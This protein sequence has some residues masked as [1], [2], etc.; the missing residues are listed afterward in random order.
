VQGDWPGAAKYW[1]RSTAIIERRADL[2]S[3]RFQDGSSKAEQAS[4]LA[5][6]FSGLVKTTYRLEA[7][8]DAARDR[9]AREMFRKA[10]WVQSSK[11]AASLALMA[12]RSAKGSPNLAILVRE[13][14]DL[15]AEWQAKDK[16]LIEWESE[17]P[18]QRN[19]VANDALL[20]RLRAIDARLDVIHQRLAQE[21]PEYTAL[22]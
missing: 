13:Q 19:Q 5:W 12:S 14:Q 20:D 10:Q 4:R 22:A 9:Q 3:A 21:L 17:E 6:Q 11:A 1:D 16:Q 7:K 18:E 15:F 8:D 2:G